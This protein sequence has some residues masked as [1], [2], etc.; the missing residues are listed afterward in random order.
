[1]DDSFE[2]EKIGLTCAEVGRIGG[3]GNGVCLL[4]FGNCP[5]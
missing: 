5:D 3:K 4:D 2:F 1:M